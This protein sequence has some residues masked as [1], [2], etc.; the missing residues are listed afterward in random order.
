MSCGTNDDGAIKFLHCIEGWRDEADAPQ[1]IEALIST[2]VRDLPL[3]TPKRVEQGCTI[4]EAFEAFKISKYVVVDESAV[5]EFSN[6]RVFNRLAFL[7]H[8]VQAPSF[9]EPLSMVSAL[10]PSL[11]WVNGEDTLD[12]ALQK[13]IATNCEGVAIINS[14][15]VCGVLHV[16]DIYCF[17]FREVAICGD[18]DP[19]EARIDANAT[20][21][22]ADDKEKSKG[23]RVDKDKK[24]SA[25]TPIRLS[26]LEWCA[27]GW[28]ETLILFCI[29]LDMSSA[30]VEWALVQT[31]MD[32]QKLLVATGIIL[33]I[34]M[35]EMLVRLFGRRATILERPFEI[36]D[37]AIVVTS[38][39]VYCLVLSNMLGEDSKTITAV[40]VLRILRQIKLLRFFAKLYTSQQMRYRRDGF[41]LDLS[42]VTASCIAMGAP[43]LA[44][45]AYFANR[46]GELRRFF[47]TKYPGRYFVFN[48][49]PDASAYDDEL[50]GGRVARI[51]VP[52]HNPPTMPQLAAFVEH[53][54]RFLERDPEAVI[55][56]HCTSGTGR[57]GVAVA[58]WLLFSTFAHSADDAMAWFA[59]RRVGRKAPPWAG[60]PMASQR[61]YVGYMEAAIARG[62]FYTKRLFLA[63]IVVTQVPVPASAPRARGATRRALRAARPARRA[64]W[65]QIGRFG[66]A[67]SCASLQGRGRARA[68]A[69]VWTLPCARG[70]SPVK[71]RRRR[72]PAAISDSFGRACPG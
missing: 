42:Y 60:V 19:S 39:V 40:R 57:T 59:A 65:A 23:L 11:G 36:L 12:V 56:V 27:S 43:V 29:L 26:S 55:A 16:D 9:L 5:G 8:A 71:S 4:L 34:Y 62:G 70:S 51:P 35:F 30:V 68:R 53:A 15:I 25:M 41:S 64:L 22:I 63:R 13:M 44:P 72:G 7:E 45:D 31:E 47:T 50:F 18:Y 52:N 33:Y 2:P 54:A 3:H 6:F 28:T 46:A 58:A 69:R 20:F 61:R 14:G 38:S 21:R 37:T 17:M 48:L 67:R 1:Y 49:S 32:Q 24:S 66:P 10:I